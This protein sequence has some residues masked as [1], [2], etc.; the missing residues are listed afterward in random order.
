MTDDRRQTTDDSLIFSSIGIFT[1]LLML[2]DHCRT[3][4]RKVS[5]YSTVRAF[6]PIDPTPIRVAP[7]PKCRKRMNNVFLDHRGFPDQSNKYDHVLHN[8]EGGPILRKLHHP[9]PIL[10][11]DVDPAFYAPFIPVKHEDQMR[12]T[13]ELVPPGSRPPREDLRH[14]LKIMVYI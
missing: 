8:V 3:P 13:F 9:T 1:H 12:K 6:A 14:N 4:C 2:F 10:D 7:K 11:D 5:T